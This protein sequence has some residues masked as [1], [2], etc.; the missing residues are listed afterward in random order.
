MSENRSP[1]SESKE[2]AVFPFFQEEYRELLP[3]I[4]HLYQQAEYW[5]GTGRMLWKDDV[6]VDVLDSIADKGGLEPQPDKFDIR[7]GAGKIVALTD[8]RSYG[9]SYAQMF[10]AD[11]EDLGYEYISR[12]E[13][14]KAILTGAI[15][16]GLKSLPSDILHGNLRNILE[17]TMRRGKAREWHAKV[18]KH[19]SDVYKDRPWTIRS[20]ISGNY[21]MLI[22]VKGGGLQLSKTSGVVAALHEV[23]TNNLIPLD[24]F[25]H[26]EVPYR[27]VGTTKSFLESRS[28][29]NTVIPMEFGEKYSSQFSKKALL[30]GNPF[31][32]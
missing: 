14:A 5:H 17:L 29:P 26:I 32:K 13:V 2:R 24:D 6:V 12:E 4:I 8:I 7:T 10:L 20:D 19:K 31:K 9:R 3:E 21:P 25:T 23:R 1:S 16:P 18:R 15:L 28:I 30:S 27:N 11:N 22:S